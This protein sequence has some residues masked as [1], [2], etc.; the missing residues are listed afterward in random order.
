MIFGAQD[1]EFDG[2]IWNETAWQSDAGIT[3]GLRDAGDLSAP[4]VFQRD[5]YWYLIT[6]ANDGLF[7]GYNLTQNRTS[8]TVTASKSGYSSGSVSDLNATQKTIAS[9]TATITASSNPPQPPGGGGGTSGGGSSGGGCTES[10]QCT[11]WSACSNDLETRTCIDVKN[12]NTTRNKPLTERSCESVPGMELVLGQVSMNAGQCQSAQLT[13]RNTGTED[14]KNVYASKRI[15][16]PDCCTITSERTIETIY[17][18][19]Y[20]IIYLEVCA[21]KTSL[22]G[23]YTYEVSVASNTLTQKISSSVAILKSY[24]EVLF[25]LIADTRAGFEALGAGLTSDQQ[26]QKQQGLDALQSAENSAKAGNYND[27]ENFIADA[28]AALEKARQAQPGT[29]ILPM[30]ITV[31]IVAGIIAGAFYYLTK[32]HKPAPTK[33][34]VKITTE[35]QEI[36]AKINSVRSKMSKFSP[37]KLGETERIYYTKTL[38]ALNRSEGYL[39][40]G[41]LKTA[42]RYLTDA[43]TYMR[44]MEYRIETQKLKDVLKK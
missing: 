12:C 6:G 19:S 26:Q 41:D 44:V 17:A 11:E 9:L 15:E 35:E 22:A 24:Q 29:D 33:P 8:M 31:I 7:Y 39:R 40:R 25:D 27:A 43:E 2:F 21:S 38:D 5:S 16:V 14:L 28:R 36:A 37:E 42:K 4:A 10:W 1:G 23:Q 20:D 3:S 32:Y 18:G 34:A 30:L 13:I